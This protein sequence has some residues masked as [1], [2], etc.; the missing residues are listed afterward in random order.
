MV[1]EPGDIVGQAPR[2]V[3]AAACNFT[4]RQVLRH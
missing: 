1:Q 4:L 3:D 2:F